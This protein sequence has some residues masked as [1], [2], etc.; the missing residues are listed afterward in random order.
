MTESWDAIVIGGGLA[1]GAA[2]ITLA[3]AGR[4]ILLLEK[5]TQPH[6]KICGEFISFEAQYYLDRL[7]I[8]ID[9]LGAVPIN[10][11]ELVQRS[12][13]IAAPL[14]FLGKSLSRRTL[15]EA[16]LQEAKRCG[17]VVQ[18]GAYV[19]D[20]KQADGLVQVFVGDTSYQARVAFHAT[21]KRDLKPFP[22]GGGVYRF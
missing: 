22:R 6:H 21:G 3:K 14:P 15:D 5:E 13:S 2:S 1:G 18:R 19:T 17:V 20:V 12:R 11:I 7:G 16:L 4:R 10:Q 9:A 8:D